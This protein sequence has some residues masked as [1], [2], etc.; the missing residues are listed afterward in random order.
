MP[1]TEGRSW[2]RFDESCQLAL[3]GGAAVWLSGWLAVCGPPLVAVAVLSV[4]F[5]WLPAQ[6]Q[7][8]L[9][10]LASRPTQLCLFPLASCPN[11]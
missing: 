6:T 7:I 3:D 10:P 11:P 9:F 2:H 8:C 1:L 4:Y 5:L